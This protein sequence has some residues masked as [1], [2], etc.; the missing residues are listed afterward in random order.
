MEGVKQQHASWKLVVNITFKNEMYGFYTCLFE[1]SDPGVS[2]CTMLGSAVARL[3]GFRDRIPPVAL[4]S[5]AYK[6]CVSSGRGKCDGAIT[7]TEESYRLWCVCVIEEPQRGGLRRQGL[8]SHDRVFE[9][10]PV[11]Y[12]RIF[13]DRPVLYIR[14]FEDRPALYIRVFEDRPALYIKSK[15]DHS[16]V[17]IGPI[18]LFV[19]LPL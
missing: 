8:S 7:C 12:I 3:L 11:L 15:G 1:N 17:E 13:E 10:R 5:V 14:V 16:Y 2:G 6:C 18:Q 19:L 9:D 4:M